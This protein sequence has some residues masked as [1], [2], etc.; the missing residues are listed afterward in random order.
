MPDSYRIKKE[1]RFLFS[2]L[3]FYIFLSGMIIAIAIYS[4]NAVKH[5][6]KVIIT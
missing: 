2:A 5:D 4:S 1:R 3:F 6:A